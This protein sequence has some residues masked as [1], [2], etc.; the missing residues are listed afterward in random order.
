MQSF[1]IKNKLGLHARAAA[2]FVK[3]T[4][5]YKSDV[6]VEKDGQII[7]GKSIMGVLMLAAAKGSTITISIR[8]EDCDDLMRELEQLIKKNFNED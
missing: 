5:H 6:D 2:S 4:S 3:I 8:G 7:N 1:K